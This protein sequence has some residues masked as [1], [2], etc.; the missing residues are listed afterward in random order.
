MWKKISS[1]EGNYEVSALGE[2][3]NANTGRVL[4]LS[5]VNGYLGVTVRPGG[6]SCKSINIRVHRC[7]A[8]EFVLGHFD[9]AVVNHKDGNKLNNKA[10][11]LEWVTLSENTTH[12]YGTGLLVQPKGLNSKMSILSAEDVEYIKNDSRS[13]RAVAECLGISKDTVLRVRRGLR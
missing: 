6:R 7:V 1:V 4:S 2:I 5:V 10:A 8:K 11:N 13:S 3:R 9:G 12:A